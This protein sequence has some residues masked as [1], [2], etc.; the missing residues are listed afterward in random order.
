MSMPLVKAKRDIR[1]SDDAIKHLYEK[2]QGHPY[3]LAF[4]IKDIVDLKKKGEIKIDFINSHWKYL[5]THLSEEKFEKDIMRISPKRR[6]LLKGIAAIDKEI[7]TRQDVKANDRYWHDLTAIGTLI[8]VDR[9][10]YKL[11]HPLFKEYIRNLLKY[12]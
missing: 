12:I 5:L 8:K 4:L 2:T 11:Y 9:G 10:Q 6:E 1:F 3:F 7:V